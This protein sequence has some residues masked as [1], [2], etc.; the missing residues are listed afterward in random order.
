MI[1]GNLPQIEVRPYYTSSMSLLKSHRQHATVSITPN[2]RSILNQIIHASYKKKKRRYITSIIPT[3]QRRRRDGMEIC[4]QEFCRQRK[5][6]V[7]SRACYFARAR[8]RE[9]FA[10]RNRTIS[11]ARAIRRKICKHRKRERTGIYLPS[12]TWIN[13]PNPRALSCHALRAMSSVL[14]CAALAQDTDISL[15]SRLFYRIC[16]STMTS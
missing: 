15:L 14:R 6:G 4:D 11:L 1:A 2:K 9:R 3:F 7:V 16:H 10:D 13:Q 12:W 8:S 5:K